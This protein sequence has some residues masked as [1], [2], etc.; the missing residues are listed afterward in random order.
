MVDTSGKVTAV[1]AGTAT[2]TATAVDGSEKYD[3]CTVTVTKTSVT[4]VTLDQTSLTLTEGDSETLTATVEPS[5]ATNKNVTWS[6][7]DPN[8]ATVEN[9]VVTAVGAGTATITVTTEDG[10]KTATCTVTVE[11]PYVPPANPNYR[12]DVT[13]TAG[14]TVDK[15]PAAAKA[16]ETV[17]LTPTPEEG[18]EVGEV[19]V[20]DR[21]GDAVEVIENANGT[22]TFTM[23]NGQVKVEVTFVEAAPEPLPFTDV[24][25]GDWF[26]DAV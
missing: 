6:S 20:T 13:T 3:T 17:T 19:T 24:A 23:P 9:G 4:G 7:S 8:V 22:Y 14:G 12:I 1:G 10:G 18:Y 25:E 21:F 16:G 11:R 5:N 2:I 26:H 15:D